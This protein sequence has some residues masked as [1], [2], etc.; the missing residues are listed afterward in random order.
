MTRNLCGLFSLL[1]ACVSP[2]APVF[3]LSTTALQ[4]DCSSGGDDTVAV[5]AAINAGQCL[6]AGTF[7]VDAPAL[8]ANGRRRDAMLTGA[9]LCGAGEELTTVLFRGDAHLLYWVGVNL[10]ANAEVHHVTLD[11]TCLTDVV[12]QTHV[13]RAWTGADHA[14]IHDA[15]FRHPKR[16]NGVKPGDCVNVVGPGYVAG[17]PYTPIQGMT[18]DHVAFESCGRGG[19]QVSRGLDHLKVSNSTFGACGFDVGSEGAGFKDSATGTIVRTLT[20]VELDH[21][22]FGSP[23]TSGYSLEFEWVGGASVHDNVSDARPWFIYYSDDVATASNVVT[24]V[25]SAPVVNLADENHRFSSTN[26]LLTQA[27][28]NFEVVRAAALDTNRQA[29]LGGLSITGSQLNQGGAADFVVLS[30]VVGAAVT[31]VT[32][33]YIGPSTRVP[34]SVVQRTSGGVAP[35]VAV[36][37][38]AVVETGTIRV[39]W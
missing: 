32:M 21:N 26:D 2:P 37:T 39:G 3:D 18:I 38:S 25:T 35:A 23:Y 12:E 4:V 8:G 6:P 36:P 20:N 29:D 16:A 10:T 24:N 34:A 30:G 31:G 5:Q 17:Q 9:K 33:V 15:L 11:T 1:L 14:Y 28:A 7:R 22:H 27:V 19:V 13:T